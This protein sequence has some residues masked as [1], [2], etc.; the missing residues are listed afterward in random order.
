MWVLALCQTS[1]NPQC[2]TRSEWQGEGGTSTLMIPHY[3]CDLSDGH[4]FWPRPSVYKYVYAVYKLYIYNVYI[5]MFSTYMKP[6]V[7]SS[8]QMNAR[9]ITPKLVS[10]INPPGF[11]Q[12]NLSSW[13]ATS[14]RFTMCKCDR[15][16]FLVISGGCLTKGRN[17]PT[18]SGFSTQLPPLRY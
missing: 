10:H 6:L 9:V 11:D 12:T 15:S 8:W 4:C 16:A 7:E 14:I 17:N 18:G 2:L 13:T 5:Y 1:K 3:I